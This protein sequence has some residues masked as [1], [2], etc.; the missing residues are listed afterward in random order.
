MKQLMWMFAGWQFCTSRMEWNA[1]GE[2]QPLSKWNFLKFY[3]T[4]VIK[5]EASLAR[6]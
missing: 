1:T 2:N 3:L 5:T 4:E 6:D